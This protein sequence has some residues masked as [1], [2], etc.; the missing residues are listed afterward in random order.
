[1]KKLD[2]LFPGRSAEINMPDPDGVWE[3]SP[4]EGMIRRRVVPGKDTIGDI[5]ISYWVPKDLEVGRQCSILGW[6]DENG[7]IKK[8][9]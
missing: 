7:H 1:M 3:Y 4:D 6:I 8:L 9:D 2:D 5:R